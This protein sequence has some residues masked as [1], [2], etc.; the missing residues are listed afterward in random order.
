MVIPSLSLCNL[1]SRTINRP[2]IIFFQKISVLLLLLF[3][4][5]AAGAWF[6]LFKTAE[7]RCEDTF[8]CDSGGWP[9][10]GIPSTNMGSASIQEVSNNLSRQGSACPLALMNQYLR[11]CDSGLITDST[12]EK[13]AEEC[14]IATSSL[15]NIELEKQILEKMD[16]DIPGIQHCIQQPFTTKPFGSYFG[17][18]K[19]KTI[20]EDK[21]QSFI[22]EYYVTAKR[23]QDRLKNQFHNIAAID[24]LI[25]EDQMLED[26]DCE[27]SVSQEAQTECEQLQQCN[28][29]SSK[30]ESKKRLNELSSGTV[31]A[32][33]VK[34]ELEKTEEACKLKSHSSRRPQIRD[35]KKCHEK[36]EIVETDKDGNQIKKKV[37]KKK[38]LE[39]QVALYK[40]LYPWIIGKTFNKGIENSDILEKIQNLN[41]KT[42]DKEL[43]NIQNEVAKNIKTQLKKTKKAL[44]ESIKGTKKTY[45]CMIKNEDCKN[46][47][48]GVANLD[49]TQYGYMN[50]IIQTSPPIH[51]D[52]LSSGGSTSNSNLLAP[53]FEEAQCQQNQRQIAEKNQ[54]KEKSLALDA[55]VLAGSIILLIPS[56]ST[57]SLAITATMT[58]LGLTTARV[59]QLATATNKAKLAINT[60]KLLKIGVIGGDAAA[61]GLIANEAVNTCSNDIENL[62]LSINQKNTG[63]IC[64]NLSATAQHTSSLKS[65][66]TQASIA[67][68]AVAIPGGV[69]LK[70]LL[71]R[72]TPIGKGLDRVTTNNGSNGTQVAKTD[73]SKNGSNVVKK[74]S[75]GTQVAKTDGSKAPVTN[76]QAGGKVNNGSNGTQVAKT[77]GSKAPVTN[78]QAGGKVNN[79]SNG[80]QVAQTDG[81]KAP[82]TNAQAGGKVNNGSNGTQVAKTDGSNGTQVAR[83][84]GSKN[85]SN[86][87]K[88]GSNGTQVAKT[89]GSKAPVT[90]AQAGGK[91]NN[92][93]NGT[94]VA[95]T[96]GSKAP[97]TNAQA[98]GKVN[99][100]SN[101][102]QVAQ[103]DGS[104]APVT[105]AQAGGKVNN[106][107]NGTQVA[108]TDGSNGTQVARTDGSKNGSN[109]V[110][111]GS[112]GTQVAKTDGSNGTQV[113]K[114][115]ESKNG[116]NVV[117]KGSSDAAST[118]SKGKEIVPYTPLTPSLQRVTKN[119]SNKVITTK[120]NGSSNTFGKDLIT[121]N[122]LPATKSTSVKE[123]VL[124]GEYISKS[125]SSKPRNSDRGG[126]TIEGS[127]IRQSS[128]KPK[129]N[130]LPN[131]KGGGKEA[132]AAGRSLYTIA[133]SGTRIAGNV[134]GATLTSPSLADGIAAETN[135]QTQQNSSQK[136]NNSSSE[137]SQNSYNQ[138]KKANSLKNCSSNLTPNSYLSRICALRAQIRQLDSDILGA[139]SMN[140]QLAQQLWGGV[141]N[142]IIGTQFLSQM[143]QF[144]QNKKAAT[145]E[146]QY[147]SRYMKNISILQD[148]VNNNQNAQTRR[149]LN[150]LINNFDQYMKTPKS[151]R[152]PDQI[153]NIRER[154]SILDRMTSA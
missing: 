16:S 68:L 110:K 104:K 42:R 127:F 13:V 12:E 89:D 23:L 84:D 37:Y 4:N 25:G 88:K 20:P 53:Y 69:L 10:Q 67:T 145:I 54:K 17:N 78:A 96:D 66:I 7:E 150:N 75:N 105:N 34:R 149:K 74:G 114:T 106:G 154:I 148:R 31:T 6:W 97:V 51:P 152:N 52:L 19:L 41:D 102:T 119:N 116:S 128:G 115:D 8:K 117:K 93:S 99:N 24:Q 46:I 87:V 123:K 11:D 82:V 129:D 22:T 103:T 130:K 1:W 100:G 71:N 63:D 70:S 62:D 94:Q 59:G 86:V 61:T 137:E 151:E 146:Y 118:I 55:V 76:A 132:N 3:M 49:S 92:G 28:T 26:V 109:V 143:E 38:Y 107:S 147:L 30:E 83:T 21:H 135:K 18:S 80:T 39:G 113:A 144:L 95:K 138:N 90:N 48:D 142:N 79:G 122:H 77:D 33:A 98:G 85:G 65:C 73:G 2:L 134:A 5:N 14:K 153:Q 141:K 40:E 111:K 45:K 136:D 44:S 108:K 133:T 56:G 131:N 32:L 9:A 47:P 57:S 125:N 64:T 81:S 60:K 126:A 29:S 91:V 140:K 139:R 58:R 27:Q 72:T 101:G 36:I 124:D 35:K 121:Q 120:N 43:K 112:N 15:T 50:K